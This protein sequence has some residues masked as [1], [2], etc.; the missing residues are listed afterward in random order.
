MLTQGVIEDLQKWDGLI[1]GLDKIV[2]SIH[3]GSYDEDFIPAH[4]LKCLIDNTGP[5]VQK[6]HHKKKDGSTGI[7][8]SYKNKE[9][10]RII[11]VTA[12]CIWGKSYAQYSF[13]PSKL[14]QEDWVEIADHMGNHFDN[15]IHTLFKIGRVKR[16]EAYVDLL[17]VHNESVISISTRCHSYEVYNGEEV[18][19]EYSG[20]I[21]SPL[22]LIAYNK[23]EQ[24][25]KDTKIDIGYERTRVE[26]RLNLPETTLHGLASNGLKD[27]WESTYVVLPELLEQHCI[28]SNMPKGFYNSLRKIGL[29]ETMKQFKINP[30]AKKA[31]IGSLPKLN[32]PLWLQGEFWAVHMDLIKRCLPDYQP[33]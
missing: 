26:A 5:W 12:G 2:L 23:R 25:I 17:N 14:T 15:G 22:S 19:S 7:S 28:K 13:N 4:Q 3:Q 1:L 10:K 8:V 27:P 20:S 29:Y 31:F 24:L 33:E 9:G 32:H 18:D 6:Y 16:L 11:G 30:P 21:T